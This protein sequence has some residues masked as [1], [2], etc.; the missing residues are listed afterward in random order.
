MDFPTFQGLIFRFH[1]KFRVV[2]QLRPRNLKW[3]PLEKEKHLQNIDFW[4]S[5]LVLRVYRGMN[6]DHTH[7]KKNPEHVRWAQPEFHKR[8][9]KRKNKPD[10]L[11]A[12][13]TVPYI[14]GSMHVSQNHELQ[15]SIR[16]N[17]VLQTSYTLP[18]LFVWLF[19]LYKTFPWTPKP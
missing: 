18:E 10:L 19:L 15:K 3:S 13:G 2:Y 17:I 4:V 8:K 6:K 7:P 11:Q 12:N 5:M 9:S 16:S 14:L 1:V